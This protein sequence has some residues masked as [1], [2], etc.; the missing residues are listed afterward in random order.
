MHVS[1]YIYIHFAYIYI[2]IHTSTCKYI[3]IYNY[4]PGP[5]FSQTPAFTNQRVEAVRRLLLPFGVCII[6]CLHWEKTDK[7]ATGKSLGAGC[8]EI[9][10]C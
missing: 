10:L 7:R 2:Y 4:T 3:Y 5:G 8:V 1:I 6:Q 9:T